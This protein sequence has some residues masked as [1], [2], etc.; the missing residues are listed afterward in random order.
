MTQYYFLASLLSTLEIGH[1]PALPMGELKELLA[2]NLTSEDLEK[3]KELF[4]LIDLHNF[5]ALLAGEPLDPFGNYNQEALEFALLH[6]VYPDGEPLPSSIAEYFDQYPTKEQRLT[7]FSLLEQRFFAEKIATTNAFLHRYFAF[8]RE[9]RLVMIGFRAKKMGRNLDAELQYEE[10]SDPLVA[11]ILAQKDARTYDPPFEYKEL[12]PL[13]ERD[14]ERPLALHRALEEYR[15]REVQE[16]YGGDSF[17]ID[18]ILGHLARL[19]LVEKWLQMDVSRGLEVIEAIER[20][21]G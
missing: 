16:L 12:K 3:V 20:K 6:G 9:W 2:I 17:S 13:F 18:R 1:R 19:Y 21:I 14:E 4:S 7:H 10:S 8:E 5:R 15:F 11:Q